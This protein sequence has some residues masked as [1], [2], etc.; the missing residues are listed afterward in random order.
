MY[1]V[2][3]HLRKDFEIMHIMADGNLENNRKA[4][5]RMMEYLKISPELLS[6]HE[7]EDPVERAYVE[8]GEKSALKHPKK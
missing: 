8:M 6:F 1:L 4:E 7:I 5:R 3:R 2:C